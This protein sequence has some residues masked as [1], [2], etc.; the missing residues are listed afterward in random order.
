MWLGTQE[1]FREPQ[2]KVCPEPAFAVLEEPIAFISAAI[3]RECF[4]DFSADS[5]KGDKLPFYDSTDWANF[6]LQLPALRD[7]QPLIGFGS[8]KAAG[9][10]IRTVFRNKPSQR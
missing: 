6:E 4:S 5:R 3:T 9:R 1:A 2:V 10:K 7:S 8:E